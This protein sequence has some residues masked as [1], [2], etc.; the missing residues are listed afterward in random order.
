M[1]RIR[2]KALLKIITTKA[3]EWQPFAIVH[4]CA[5]GTTISYYAT[6]F[7]PYMIIIYIHPMESNSSR[8]VMD[9]YLMSTE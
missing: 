4:I 6:C 5:F 9:A 1:R 2:E 7:A 8:M 3:S